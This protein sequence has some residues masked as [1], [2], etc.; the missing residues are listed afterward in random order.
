MA[1]HGAPGEIQEW[2]NLQTMMGDKVRW[3][4]FAMPGFDG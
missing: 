4:N 1:I 3:I 2:M